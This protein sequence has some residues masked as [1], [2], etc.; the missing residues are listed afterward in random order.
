MHETATVAYDTSLSEEQLAVRA[1]ARDFAEQEIRPIVMEFDES[2]EFP[3]EI[4][5]KMADLGF[6]GITVPTELDGSGL[7]FVEYALIVEE[8]AR[9]DPSI[10]LG[11]AAHN[12][13]CT[14]LYSCGRLPYAAIA[15]ARVE[16]RWRVASVTVAPPSFISE[17]ARSTSARTACWRSRVASR[18][19]TSRPLSARRWRSRIWSPAAVSRSNSSRAC[20]YTWLT[21]HA[22]IDG[23]ASPFTSAASS[24]RPSRLSSAARAFRSGTK[25]SSG[26][27]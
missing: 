6:L 4:F 17:T 16:I 7:G 1:L 8:I 12:G 20:Q 22:G 2:Q 19:S 26:T 14:G 25:R 24:P 18:R 15:S 10:A 23:R 5:R 11:V 21:A 27:P 13:L 9:I 3:T